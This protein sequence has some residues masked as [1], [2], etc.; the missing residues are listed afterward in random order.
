MESKL[1]TILGQDFIQLIDMNPMHDHSYSVHARNKSGIPVFIGGI[2]DEN[3]A[4]KLANAYY[5]S[6]SELELAGFAVYV[7]RNHDD[8]LIKTF[9]K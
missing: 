1:E 9:K 7:V 6:H 8:T 3:D 2:N 4:V 5:T